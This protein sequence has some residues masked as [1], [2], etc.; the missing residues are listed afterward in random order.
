[1]ASSGNGFK[2]RDY[3]NIEI[4]LQIL[5]VTYK[6]IGDLF[7]AKSMYTFSG[8]GPVHAHVPIHTCP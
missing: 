7:T 5:L 1:M 2:Y 8:G 6:K 3:Q 4:V